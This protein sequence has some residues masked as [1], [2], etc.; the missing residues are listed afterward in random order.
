MSRIVAVEPFVFRYP[1]AEPITTSFGIMRDRPA[2]FVRLRDDEGASG[3]GE[4][5]CNF[6]ICGAEHRARLI[7]ST[8]EPLALGRA[9]NEPAALFAELSQATEV[10]AIQSG[11][12]GPIAQCLSGIDI[13]AWDLAARRAG[14]PLWR[15]L[16]GTDP[17]ISVYASGIN[18]K[19][20][21]AMATAKLA[22][23]H[24]AFKVKVGFGEERDLF[25]LEE[26]RSA[27]GPSHSLMVDANQAWEFEQAGRMAKLMERFGLAWVEEPLRAD[28]PLQ[29]WKALSRRSLVALAGGENVAS[30]AAFG[31]VI[32]SRALA[33]VQP[34][35]C[36]WGGISKCLPLARRIRSAG[37]TY[38]PHSLGGG[39]GL[40]ASAHV[41]AAC[42]GEGM[43][44]IDSNPNALRTEVSGAL[45]EIRKGRARL[46]ESAGLGCEPDLA[47]LEAF[48]VSLSRAA[49]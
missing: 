24:R 14:L 35:L 6:P 9:V 38:C 22:E 39:L 34:D 11:E 25:N 16:G 26:V 42:G 36:K 28:R 27:I 49:V 17:E 37:L 21:G 40:L 20:S 5:W 46:S 45:N 12:L 2:L 1:I 41:L 18:P 43:L 29:E 30:E 10:L 32:A 23:G 31:A 7:S 48:A 47:T 33:Y 15:H 13:A 3:W 8:F 44:E 4:V 19:D